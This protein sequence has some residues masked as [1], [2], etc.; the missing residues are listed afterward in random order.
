MSLL[1][2]VSKVQKDIVFSPRFTGIEAKY[3]RRIENSECDSP[4]TKY[5]LTP[6]QILIMGKAPKRELWDMTASLQQTFMQC[7]LSRP[8]RLPTL[9]DLNPIRRAEQDDEE[10]VDIFSIDDKIIEKAL[11]LGG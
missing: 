4:E 3:S 6:R 5:T 2:F 7:G 1:H 9:T 10:S 8:R 11:L